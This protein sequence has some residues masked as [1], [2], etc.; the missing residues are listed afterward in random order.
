[1]PE[2]IKDAAMNYVLYQRKDML[3]GNGVPTREMR[4]YLTF[5]YKEMT[6]AF[7]A[8]AKWMAKLPPYNAVLSPPTFKPTL[9]EKKMRELLESSEMH[10]RFSMHDFLEQSILQMRFI[11]DSNGD[12]MRNPIDD[13]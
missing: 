9:D 10:S 5:S 12:M 3:H 6:N 4:E 1:M 11:Q 8:G 7:E 13:L 2:K